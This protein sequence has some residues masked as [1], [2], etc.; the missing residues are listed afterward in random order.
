MPQENARAKVACHL[1]HTRRVKCDRT[2]EVPCSN[3]RVAGCLCAP[4]QLSGEGA[5]LAHPDT[6]CDRNEHCFP[7]LGHNGKTP[8]IGD[9]SN[10]NYL[11]QQCGNPFRTTA[12]TRPLEDLLQEAMLA[13]LGKPTAQHIERLH[14]ADSLVDTYFRCSFPA[15]PVLDKLEFLEALQQGTVSRL[16]LNAVYLAASLY[17][18][19]SVIAAAGF[20]SRYVASL[21]FYHRAKSLYDAGYET[22]AVAIIQATFLIESYIRLEKKR[23]SLW[24][25]LRWSV[26]RLCDVPTLSV[27]DFDLTPES[28]E[29]DSMGGTHLDRC[30]TIKLADFNSQSRDLCLDQISQ[31]SSS[32]PPELQHLS[33]YSSPWAMLIQLLHHAY[34]LLLHRNNPGLSQNTG[35]GTPTFEICAEIS[36]MVEFLLTRD[37]LYVAAA[38]ILP[39]VLAT[40]SIQLVNLYR[41][42]VG[43]RLISEHRARFCMFILDK[44]EDRWPIVASFY[45]LFE[46]LLKRCSIDVPARDKPSRAGRPERASPMDD[47]ATRKAHSEDDFGM[48]HA[49]GSFHQR[50]QE[51]ANIIFPSS[52]PFSSLLE[53][54][55]LTHPPR[56]LGLMR[57]P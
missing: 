8:Y 20:T 14:T 22:D 27:D 47:D 10:L 19:D 44:L 24:R 9:S 12:D 13:R 42:D 36:H 41:G 53:D 17:C 3:C 40:L 18:S 35:P 38:S 50:L 54:I 4:I 25:R 48:D 51:D 46:S 29:R 26:Y 7:A 1:C 32:L 11:I 2:E 34:R 56:S 21:T 49:G 55:F 15:M 6:H 45:S 52:F 16:L 5:P 30:Y 57:A 43:A 28:D 31:W 39:P 37:L 23:R 33:A